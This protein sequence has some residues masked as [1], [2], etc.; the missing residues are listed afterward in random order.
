MR[1][2]VSMGV[3]LG[4]LDHTVQPPGWCSEHT[5]VSWLSCPWSLSST[6]SFV[7]SYRS[8]VT[9]AWKALLLKCPLPE[10]MRSLF[11]TTDL[12]FLHDNDSRGSRS[13]VLYSGASDVRTLAPPFGCTHEGP[14]AWFPLRSSIRWCLLMTAVET[15]PRVGSVRNERRAA[16]V[17]HAGARPD[18]LRCEPR[19]RTSW[20]QTRLPRVLNSPPTGRQVLSDDEMRARYDQFGEAG[21]SGAASAGMYDV[22]SAA[23]HK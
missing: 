14:V 11:E 23:A 20:E 10:K 5:L 3:P 2:S 1:L 9:L 13:R 4:C 17:P 8:S 18:S 15:V 22:R 19:S 6:T 21:V 7:E 16:L 12:F